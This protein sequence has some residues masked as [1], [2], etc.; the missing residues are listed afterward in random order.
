MM[1]NIRN[2]FSRTALTQQEV[3]TL[4]GIISSLTRLHVRRKEKADG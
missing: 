2:I 4:R 1:V 3:S